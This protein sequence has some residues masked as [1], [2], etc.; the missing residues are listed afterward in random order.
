MPLLCVCFVTK[1]LTAVY[2]TLMYSES[3]KSQLLLTKRSLGEYNPP[4]L[5]QVL[6]FVFDQHSW[7]LQAVLSFV[8][9]WAAITK[10]QYLCRIDWST[11]QLWE[12]DQFS[13]S[14]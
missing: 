1:S 9:G 12:D 8:W 11:G 4:S 5:S 7:S 2:I 3:E 14:S 13:F 6:K 10:H